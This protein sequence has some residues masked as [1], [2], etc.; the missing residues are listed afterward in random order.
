[1][2]AADRNTTHKD[3]DKNEAVPKNHVTPGPFL[4]T[5]PSAQPGQRNA[6]CGAFV[7]SPGNRWKSPRP[8]ELRTLKLDKLRRPESANRRENHTNKRDRY[9]GR[10]WQ[11]TLPQTIEGNQQEGQSLH[12]SDRQKLGTRDE[13]S[14]A[15][16]KTNTTPQRPKPSQRP[17][18][19]RELTPERMRSRR[20]APWTKTPQK[21]H[22]AEPQTEQRQESNTS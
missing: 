12:G 18:E 4:V 14:Q 19:P 8:K 5:G 6:S 13:P 11:T 7:P 2:K 21:E 16:N 9:G 1:M 22:H 10:H 3:N 17:E 20:A 15:M